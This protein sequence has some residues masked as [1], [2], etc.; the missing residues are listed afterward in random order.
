MDK[1]AF[2]YEDEAIKSYVSE[3]IAVIK[4]KGNVFD[5]ITDLAESGKILSFIN[6]AERASYIKVLLMISEPGALGDVEFG[7]FIQR[8]QPQQEGDSDE[9]KPVFEKLDRTR[10]INILNRVISQLVEFKKIS[11]M[12]LQ[13]D[14]V[15][16]FFGGSLAMDFRYASED[17]VYSLSHL[18]YGIHPGGALPFFLQ[19]YLGHSKAVEILF[20]G[21]TITA[22]EA[23]ELGL[24]NE[25]LP[26]HDFENQCLVELQKFCHLEQRVINTTKL[27]INFSR[28]ALRHYFDLESALLH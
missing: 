16:P 3:N 13:G 28:T 4:I 10:E 19:H 21:G 5:T 8:M 12:A 20:K 7:K 24:I 25:I 22:K 27:L 26:T 11:V 18:K 15:T 1:N 23:K 6:K 9:K 17:M 14:I 2:N